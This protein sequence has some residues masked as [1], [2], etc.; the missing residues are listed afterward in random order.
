MVACWKGLIG[1]PHFACT[2]T[3]LIRWVTNELRL[4]GCLFCPQPRVTRRLISSS[5]VTHSA[6]PCWEL[7]CPAEHLP[8][9]PNPRVNRVRSEMKDTLWRCLRVASVGLCN[10]RVLLVLL[11]FCCR[12]KEDQWDVHGREGMSLAA[13]DLLSEPAPSHPRSQPPRQPVPCQELPTHS[14]DGPR[15]GV[16]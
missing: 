9:C 6:P 5:P 15:E 16:I 8:Q 4:T 10:P 3:L 11:E 2:R 13:W 14:S 7:G 1:V 12:R